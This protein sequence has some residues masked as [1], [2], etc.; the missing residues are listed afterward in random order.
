MTYRICRIQSLLRRAEALRR[1]QAELAAEICDLGGGQPSGPDLLDPMLL[2]ILE[3]EKNKQTLELPPGVLRS[4]LKRLLGLGSDAV[5]DNHGSLASAAEAEEFA[6]LI[7]EGGEFPPPPEGMFSKDPEPADAFMARIQASLEQFKEMVAGRKARARNQVEDYIEDEELEG[8]DIESLLNGDIPVFDEELTESVPAP[9]IP[10]EALA[11]AL[12]AHRVLLI[13]RRAF[14]ADDAIGLMTPLQAL[15]DRALVSEDFEFQDPWICLEG[16]EATRDYLSEATE[17]GGA[18]ISM[19]VLFLSF[20]EYKPHV[21]GRVVAHTLLNL[22]L[23]RWYQDYLA[24]HGAPEMPPEPEYG[25]RRRA[26][27]PARVFVEDHR[28][29]PGGALYPRVHSQPLLP[30]EEEGTAHIQW[31]R[32]P[33]PA[34]TCPQLRV[35]RA[36]EGPEEGLVLYLMGMVGTPSRGKPV[37]SQT[38]PCYNRLPTGSVLLGALGDGWL[39]PL[40]PE[41]VQPP[42]LPRARPADLSHDP[43]NSDE[44][45]Q[46]L[47]GL[48][49][50][51]S[52]TEIAGQLPMKAPLQTGP[53]L[54]GHLSIG[55]TWLFEINPAGK[56]NEVQVHWQWVGGPFQEVSHAYDV[57]A[58]E[59]GLLNEDSEATSNQT[60][61]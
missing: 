28:C 29:P 54:P 4:E 39:S 34:I 52:F 60:V 44:A 3:N 10:P 1:E 38:N 21:K 9:D 15:L 30:S 14:M 35:R 18:S 27:E 58:A 40:P 25:P 22:P 33:T 17:V 19:D 57:W 20:H 61:Y 13:L 48:L 51:K 37:R 16:I 43:L 49:G 47:R 31:L 11:A 7:E 8:S 53:S 46:L 23:P 12:R 42:P 32:Q 45:E 24:L 56:V 5:D 2:N 59:T 6:R 50:D 36:S 55:A 41:Q 26:G